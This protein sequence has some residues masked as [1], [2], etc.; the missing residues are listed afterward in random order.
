VTI[1]TAAE[2]GL[3]R[4]ARTTVRLRWILIPTMFCIAIAFG[5]QIPKLTTDTSSENYLKEG[6]PDRV[7]YDN[8]R[9]QFGRDTKIAIGID[10]PE[11][12][13]LNF[14]SRLREFHEALEAEV[15]LLDDITSLINIRNTR[16]EGDRLIVED[17]LENFPETED[18]L[19]VLETRIM[20]NPLYQDFVI[21]RDGTF[22]SIIIETQAYSSLGA[23]SDV[24]AEFDREENDAGGEAPAFL[25]GEENIEIVR[26]VY[27]IA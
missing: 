25:T 27:D 10:P 19:A 24:F 18:E 26:A 14:L 23:E 17:L 3:E 9:E 6:D 21:S 20:T 5:S 12:F 4:W 22:T 2:Q 7:T 11:V 16:G 13:D 15:P 8:F 1:K